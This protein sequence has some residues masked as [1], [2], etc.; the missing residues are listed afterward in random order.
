[1]GQTADNLIARR[2]V[3]RLSDTDFVLVCARCDGGGRLGISDVAETC[4]VCAGRGRIGVQI[5]GRGPLER[6]LRCDGKGKLG[7]SF[8]AEK[9]PTCGGTGCH[10]AAGRLRTVPLDEMY[11]SPARQ[12]AIEIEKLLL[13]LSAQVPDV[14]EREFLDEALKCYQA[15]APRAAIVMC[16]NLAYDHL[17]TYILSHRLAEFNARWPKTHP[18]RHEQSRVKTIANRDDFSELKESEVLLIC[19]SASIVSG[20]VYRILDEKLGKRNSAAHPSGI[21]IGKLQAE[22]FIDEIVKNVVLK[23]VV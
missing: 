7:I 16:W 5:E 1:M 15:D 19:R 6:C 14:A 12:T 3:D 22:N 8:V 18:K 21:R 23:I 9:C 10:A 20:D 4:S 13:A 2:T 11:S 17:L